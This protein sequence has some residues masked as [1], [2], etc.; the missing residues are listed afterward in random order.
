MQTEK[1]GLELES[2]KVLARMMIDACL[3]YLSGPCAFCAL[4][5]HGLLRD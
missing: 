5:L 2:G 4:D 1:R 3:Y